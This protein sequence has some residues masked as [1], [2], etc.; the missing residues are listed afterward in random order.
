MNEIGIDP[1]NI[2][3]LTF[4]NKAAREMKSR[5]AALVPAGM[6]NGFHMHD[7]RVLR[8]VP[9]GGNIPAELS[10]VVLDNR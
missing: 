7:S 9:P 2:L 10:E 5:I 1:D 3:C 4:T 8:E 6:N